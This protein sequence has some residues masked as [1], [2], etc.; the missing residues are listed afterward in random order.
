LTRVV[1]NMLNRRIYLQ[2]PLRRY[3]FQSKSKK[4]C[5]VLNR[6]YDHYTHDHLAQHGWPSETEVIEILEAN[7]YKWRNL[8]DQ[9]FLISKDLFECCISDFYY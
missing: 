9:A 2:S 4:K 6:V 3:V 1:C 7:G 5:Y 8:Y